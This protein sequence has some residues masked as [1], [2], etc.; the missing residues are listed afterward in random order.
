MPKGPQGERRPADAVA[1]AVMVGK[2]AVGDL[3][4]DATPDRAIFRESGQ[5]GGQNR[6]KYLTPEQRREIARN[7][8]KARWH[9]PPPSG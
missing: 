2:I 4:A 3:P 1:C 9:K 7:A 5:R 6:T 8:A